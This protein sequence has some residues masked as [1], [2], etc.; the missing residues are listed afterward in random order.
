M[1]LSSHSM[2]HIEAPGSGLGNGSHNDGS[3][4]RY[5]I[6]SIVT[7][8]NSFAGGLARSAGGKPDTPTDFGEMECSP[9][10]TPL[11][12]G[13]GRSPMIEMSPDS[14]LRTGVE[15]FRRQHTRGL[16]RSPTFR[17]VRRVEEP[18]VTT[19]SAPKSRTSFRVPPV[20]PRRTRIK[21]SPKKPGPIPRRD[22]VDFTP[23]NQRI[24]RTIVTPRRQPNVKQ[25][26]P[27]IGPYI[28]GNR[29]GSGSNGTV[30]VGKN[31]MTGDLVAVKVIPKATSSDPNLSYTVAKEIGVMKLMSH[32]NV[33]Q[34]KASYEDQKN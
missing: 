7:I 12:P 27:T 5:S 6:A 15:N 34:F 32:P 23:K 28:L 33:V 29:L 24:D 13:Q 4:S 8:D 26:N 30:V 2:E 1:P 10:D 31:L 17:L 11:S 20:T 16:T 18:A 25:P 9:A 22:R 14:F 3:A 21:M 19:G